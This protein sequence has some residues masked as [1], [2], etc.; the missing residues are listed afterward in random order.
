MNKKFLCGFLAILGLLLAGCN[1]RPAADG[2]VAELSQK[3]SDLETKLDPL[4][5][6]AAIRDVK[7]AAAN[8]AK[9]VVANNHLRQVSACGEIPARLTEV[10]DYGVYPF[11]ANEQYQQVCQSKVAS[12]IQHDRQKLAAKQAKRTKLAHKG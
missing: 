5:K 7:V 12:A 4:L 2:R 6:A 10:K 3:V 9:S 8:V 11:V 1:P